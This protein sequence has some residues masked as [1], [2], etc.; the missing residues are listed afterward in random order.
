MK[1]ELRNQKN[2]EYKI[3]IHKGAKPKYADIE[4]NLI[5]FIELNRTLNNP[6]TTCC[7]SNEMFK[8]YP[9]LKTYNYRHITEWI[10]KTL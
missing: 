6:I 8:Y 3:T 1:D 9:N 10:Y 2:K 7:I 4:N 5:E